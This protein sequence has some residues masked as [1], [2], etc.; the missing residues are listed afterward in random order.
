MLPR[1]G[2][3][4]DVAGT[5][6]LTGAIIGCAIEVHRTIGPGVYETVYG[7]CMQYELAAQ[8]LHF[9]AGRPAPLIYKGTRLR[10]RFYIDLVVENQVAVELKAV[11]ALGEIHARQL[12]TQ[13]KL[14][15]L[16]VG[17]LIN[18]NVVTLTNGGVKRLINPGCARVKRRPQEISDP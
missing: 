6:K 15:D 11:A 13:L 7:E 9:E 4:V 2:M 14:T 18:F 17:L 12:L 16:P 3:L 1:F 10:S 5:N 8:K